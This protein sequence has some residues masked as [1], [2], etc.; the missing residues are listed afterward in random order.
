MSAANTMK[1]K[2]VCASPLLP[3]SEDHGCGYDTQLLDVIVPGPLHLFL[4]F[5]E[6]VNFLE[7]TQWS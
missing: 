1:W 5:N 6:I 2:G 3:I 7:K 4:S